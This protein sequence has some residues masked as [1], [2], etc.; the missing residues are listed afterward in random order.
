LSL[1]ADSTFDDYNDG[2]VAVVIESAVNP[3]GNGTIVV[4]Q[5]NVA[6]TDYHKTIDVVGWRLVDPEEPSDPEYQFPY[7]EWL[8]VGTIPAAAAAAAER[9]H[10]AQLVRLE[11]RAVHAG[12]AGVRALLLLVDGSET[13]TLTARVRHGLPVV[14][15]GLGLPV[16]GSRARLGAPP[17]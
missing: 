5:E 2:H 17:V 4:A 14:T 12:P 11:Q 16:A 3:S 7:A 13:S 10:A 15:A 8:H 6:S 9:A 1:S